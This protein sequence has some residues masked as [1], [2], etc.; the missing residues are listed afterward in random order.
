M[1]SNRWYADTAITGRSGRP[2]LLMKDLSPAAPDEPV[3]CVSCGSVCESRGWTSDL[4]LGQS[5]RQVNWQA[6]K[7]TIC[8]ACIQD[9]TGLPAGYVHLDGAFFVSHRDQVERMLKHE[10]DQAASNGSAAR[11]VG[12]DGGDYERLTVATS[13]G[14]LAQQFG[15]A[16]H[17]AFG[18]IVRYGFSREN[19]LARVWWHRD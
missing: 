6:A 14:R 12:W 8:P 17:K 1:Q 3:V 9:R 5:W 10:A 2:S 4:S 15:R 11:V 16:L 18:G 13:T 19:K 7:Q